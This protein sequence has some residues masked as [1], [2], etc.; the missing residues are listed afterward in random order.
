MRKLA[1]RLRLLPRAST[2][3]AWAEGRAAG[4]SWWQRI[5]LRF[6]AGW[7]YGYIGSAIGERR[8]LWWLRIFFAPFLL[9][10][11]HPQAW[12]DSYH[13]KVMPTDQARRLIEVHEPVDAIVPEQ[14]I[15]FEHARHLV[16]S[17]GQPVVVL[18][19]P[20][21]MSRVDPCLPL[22]V[23]LI[24]GEPFAS[25][26]LE[27]HPTRS[28]QIT[29]EGAIEILE[30]EAQRG[31]VHHAF[32]KDAMLE[33]FYAI[34]NCCSCCCGAM[35]AHFQGTPMLISSGYIAQVDPTRCQACGACANV[36]PFGA[37]SVGALAWVSAALCMGCGVC[38][39][40][41]PHHALA[42]IRDE[43]KPAP[44]DTLLQP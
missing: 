43:S 10:A 25:F 40:H 8:R 37:I 31:H 20:C 14:V 2:R 6:Y 29:P 5:H 27:H 32:F 13:G 35:M 11:L 42:L 34:C 36:C 44:L 26:V 16:I 9:K 22:D 17:R 39:R 4:Q 38:T 3:R 30:A 23:C 33:R 1:H 28:R 19:C 41:C 24:V 15:P 7:P 12:S 18:D 21:R